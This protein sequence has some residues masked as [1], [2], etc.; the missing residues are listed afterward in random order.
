[1]QPGIERLGGL[2]SC[3]GLAELVAGFLEAAGALGLEGLIEQVS[4]RIPFPQL[5]QWSSPL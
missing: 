3:H 5:L 2:F 4:Q 1:M